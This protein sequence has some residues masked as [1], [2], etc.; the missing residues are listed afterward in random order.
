MPEGWVPTN[1]F[2]EP[3]DV[4]RKG[5]KR[6]NKGNATGSFQDY[7]DLLVEQARTFALETDVVADG[8]NFTDKNNMLIEELAKEQMD[9]IKSSFCNIE[10]L[11]SRL[12]RA[13]RENIKDLTPT[14]Q[15]VALY[16][17]ETMC[18]RMTKEEK[19]L[20]KDSREKQIESRIKDPVIMTELQ[21]RNVIGGI[22]YNAKDGLR[23]PAL[24]RPME[25][26]KAF[27]WLQL[28]S[29]CR[30][31]ELLDSR[32]ASFDLSTVDDFLD[33]DVA[34][35][36]NRTAHYI[37]QVGTSK[38]KRN[39]RA[40]GSVT[41]ERFLKFLP[42]GI[43]PVVWLHVLRA[44]R[45]QVGD[46]SA[47]T[48]IQLGSKYARRLE[49][50]TKRSFFWLSPTHGTSKI[51]HKIGTHFSRAVYAQLCAL[52]EARLPR[53]TESVA[54]IVQSALCHSGR[55]NSKFYESVRVIA[56]DNKDDQDRIKELLDVQKE[57][58]RTDIVKID[59]RIFT[60]FKKQWRTEKMKRVDVERGEEILVQ[61]GVAPTT[62]HL[63]KLG[64]CSTTITRFHDKSLL[65]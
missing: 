55:N 63:K 6:K 62:A 45:F 24:A 50:E 11:K 51:P 41:Q 57:C 46:V 20:A 28:T 30:K 43:Q 32:V 2:A 10:H 15:E 54:A 47:L 18:P 42:N 39:G 31:I 8:Y 52:G 22:F 23:P 49:A 44:F 36:T 29:G 27:V 61:A 37:I 7:V 5:R 33:R 58:S 14:Q 12:R 40:R 16:T 17:V 25:F 34:I 60:K 64:L 38:Q 19:E 65:L 35:A 4:P 26:A 56:D 3:V 21:V 53:Q 1:Q 48:S 59:G 13:V 9:D